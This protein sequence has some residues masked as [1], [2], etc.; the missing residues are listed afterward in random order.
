M[1][2]T[3]IASCRTAL[4][5]TAL[6]LALGCQT[7]MCT[8]AAGDE[9]QILWHDEFEG[10]T[11]NSR[12]WSRCT[13]GKSDWD[14]HMSERADLV[15]VKDGVLICKGVKNDNV[16]EDPRPF[17]TGGVQ[18][19]DKAFME[20]GKVEIKAKFENQKGAWPALWMLGATPD[21]EGRFWPW[22]G[23]IDIMERLNS[24]P[25]IYQTVHTGWTFV[26]KQTKNPVYGAQKLPI[27]QDDWNIYGLEITDNELIWSING[28][29][30]FRYPKLENNS[31]QWPFNRPF[32]FLMDMQL[33]GAWVG[34]VD[35]NSLPV[36]M[37]IDWIRV[38]K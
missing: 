15:E 30:T 21:D 10:D 12:I 25:F 26:K 28:K 6:L 22:N 18:S 23:E 38:Y 14:R 34:K 33:G 31:E 16:K 36:N 8:T 11:L 3:K 7:K 17:L 37:Y 13:A 20:K 2:I 9:R 35:V 27:R 19:K 4:V 1:K 32:Y 5:S 29:N 24:D